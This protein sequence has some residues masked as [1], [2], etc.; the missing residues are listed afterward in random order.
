MYNG[1]E[2]MNEWVNESMRIFWQSDRMFRKK[3]DGICMYEY[4][5]SMEYGCMEYGSMKYGCIMEYGSME[6]GITEYGV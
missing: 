3:N 5:V 1:E 6:Y 2:L 4:G